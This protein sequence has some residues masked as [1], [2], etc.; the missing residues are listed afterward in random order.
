M[1]LEDILKEIEERART[2]ASEL[3]EEGEREAERIIREAEERAK[4]LISEAESRAEQ[5]KK[6]EM[7]RVRATE[8]I[9]KR[10]AILQEKKRIIADV[11]ERAVTELRQ[12]EEYE[13]FM[14]RVADA[15]KGAE[16]IVIDS[17]DKKFFGREKAL[18][19]SK[20]LGGAIITRGEITVDYSLD[21][22]L[23]ERIDDL[24]NRIEGE[25]FGY[26]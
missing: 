6:G 3:E 24:E 14:K 13:A 8:N 18:E 21:G 19:E 4:T 26:E 5:E 22:L 2:K 20:L 12:S 9:E 16:R 11:I 10:K 15:A 1:A 7:D 25:L 17:K 23:Q